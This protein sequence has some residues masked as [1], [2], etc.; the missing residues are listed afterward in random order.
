MNVPEAE[1]VESDHVASLL[2]ELGAVHFVA[3]LLK[4]LLPH[5]H[6]IADSLEGVLPVVKG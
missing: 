5:V 2:T 1:L 3:P 6:L 4:H